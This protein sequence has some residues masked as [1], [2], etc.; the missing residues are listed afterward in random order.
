[1]QVTFNVAVKLERSSTKRGIIVG[2]DADAARDSGSEKAVLIIIS[3]NKQAKFGGLRARA[4][5]CASFVDGYV[6]VPG[7][8][9]RISSCYIV[10]I[11]TVALQSMYILL[12]I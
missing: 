9:P 10:I 12:P 5:V 8:L 6:E 7:L 4:N 11:S 2:K 1:M 3:G